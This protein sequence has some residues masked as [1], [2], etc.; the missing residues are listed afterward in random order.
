MVRWRIYYADGATFDDTMGPA[1]ESPKWGAVGVQ[2]RDPF[3]NAERLEGE[4]FVYREDTERWSFHGPVGL[5]DQL[6][7]FA[8][9][10]SCVRAG[11]YV[12]SLE[13]NE[14][15]T[16]MQTDPDFK[17]SL[18]KPGGPDDAGA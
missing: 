5:A 9:D 11:R 18:N 2:Q 7:H 1:W 10:I 12:T 3:V 6:A 14:Y 17:G 16:K 13:V 8:R 15:R 4:Y